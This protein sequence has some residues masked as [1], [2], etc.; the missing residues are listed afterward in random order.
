MQMSCFQVMFCLCTV[1]ICFAANQESPAAN[2]IL[3]MRSCDRTIEWK[4][5]DRFSELHAQIVIQPRS[6]GFF[7]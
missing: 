3:L 4:T 7:I 1:L 2:K 5:E 6:Q